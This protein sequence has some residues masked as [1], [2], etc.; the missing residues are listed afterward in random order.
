MTLRRGLNRLLL[1]LLAAAVAAPASAE[2]YYDRYGNW[3]ELLPPPI[4]EDVPPG[5]DGPIYDPPPVY[6]RPPAVIYEGEVFEG[7]VRTPPPVYDAPAY[8]EPEPPPGWGGRILRTL[9]PADIPDPE[10]RRRIVRPAPEYIDPAVPR[11]FL[12]EA[13]PDSAP[14]D[15]A[16]GDPGPRGLRP[17]DPY[18]RD[19]PSNE[20][21]LEP[22]PLGEREPRRGPERA[23][24]ALDRYAPA[25]R[26][27]V[28]LS[29]PFERLAAVKTANAYLVSR[30]VLPMTAAGIRAVD[31]LLGIPVSPETTALP[32]A[33]VE[34]TDLDRGKGDAGEARRT[35]ADYAA[36]MEDALR[37]RSEEERRQIAAEAAALV[38]GSA[39]DLTTEEI[40]GL[41]AFLG[42]SDDSQ[43]A[44][45][46]P[47]GD[48]SVQ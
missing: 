40:A 38:Q 15:Q 16:W 7:D 35:I 43:V 36:I 25:K 47:D 33:G 23:I 31:R 1:S 12:L 39:K 2:G 18:F 41:D 45:R 8:A 3:V 5:Y 4:Y 17:D 34:L 30:S 21:V 13:D 29:D 44:A 14:P 27:A 22:P 37:A 6:R 48:G 11:D 32:G 9:P 24:A 42:L 10:P 28:E 26:A 46:A 20:P 19:S